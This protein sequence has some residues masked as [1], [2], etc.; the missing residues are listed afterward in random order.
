MAGSVERW[1]S[2]LN[3]IEGT[4]AWSIED[5][6]VNPRFFHAFRP[7]GRRLDEVFRGVH[8]GDEILERLRPVYAVA[9]HGLR[10]MYFIVRDPAPLIREKA[11]NLGQA[12]VAAMRDIVPTVP[13]RVEVSPGGPPEHHGELETTFYDGQC[14][15][16][17]SLE[18]EK[19]DAVLLEE[20][21]Y[22]LACDYNLARYV[23]WPLYRKASGLQDPFGPY[24][25]LW[26]AGAAV[27]YE[28]PDVCRV[29]VPRLG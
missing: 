7:D 20:P 17:R 1:R 29:W 16:V 11:L 21:L 15:Y 22:H 12:H 4:E 26:M 6:E 10:D 3:E 5:A 27:R 14:D 18:P 23:L 8:R 9:G 28:D 19:S 24:F 2:I 25:E 13:L